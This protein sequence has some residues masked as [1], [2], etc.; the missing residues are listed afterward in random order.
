M[1]EVI[2]K[3]LRDSAKARWAAMVVVSLSM[4]GAYFFNYAMSPVKPILESALGWNSADFGIYTGSYAWFNVFFLMLIFSGIIL[5]KLGIRFTGLASTAIMVIGTGINYWAIT[6]VSPSLN[7]HVIF[8]GDIKTQVLLSALGFAI[9]GVGSEATGITISKAIVKWFK[10]KEMALAMGLQMSIARI[11]TAL[12]LIVSLPLALHFNY[13]APIL[14]AFILMLIGV[15]AFITYTVMDKKLDASEKDLDLPEEEPFRISD[16]VSI[17]SNKAFWYI[18]ILCVLFYGAVFPFL[19]YAT[20]FMINKYHVAPRLA[21]IIPGLLPFGT[22]FLTPLFGGIYDKKGKGATIMIIG[23]LMLIFVHGLLAVPFLNNWIIAA[24][25]VVILGIAFSLVPSAMWPSVPKI[26]PENKLG[27]AYA[28]I[29]YIQNIGLMLIPMLL[30]YVLTATNPNV[31][32][33]KAMIK[34]SIEQS[35]RKAIA[36]NHIKANEKDIAN[37]VDKTTG[38]VVDSIVHTTFYVAK[39]QNEVSLPTV[40]NE[41]VTNNINNIHVNLGSANTL[42]GLETSFTR[43][44]FKV[45]AN[46]KLNIRYNYEYDILIFTALGILSFLFALLLKREDKK[47]GY[48]LELPNIKKEE[49]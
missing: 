20:D 23:S 8:L 2:R 12:A 28:V 41:I 4:F 6:S 22:I 46:Q 35:F 18:A 33:N 1:T 34:S 11:G 29:F 42:K 3:S 49:G 16:I 30:G 21:G 45:L 24:I 17:I 40:K 44:T 26:I 36:E 14:L 31:A 37:A 15:L 27:T 7:T 43:A 25:L 39:P 9:F 13:S 48:G 47:K 38:R 10:G 32:P 19:F 5:D